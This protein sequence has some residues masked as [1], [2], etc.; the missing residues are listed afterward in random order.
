[1]PNENEIIVGAGEGADRSGS[2]ITDCPENAQAQGQLPADQDRLPGQAGQEQE[3]RHEQEDQSREELKI[4][5]EEMQK[6]MADLSTTVQQLSGREKKRTTDKDY[7]AYR[8]LPHSE[9]WDST[10][11]T[12]K[13]FIEA[14]SFNFTLE[15]CQNMT[16]AGKKNMFLMRMPAEIRP[17]IMRMYKINEMESGATIE[18]YMHN[19][20]TIFDPPLEAEESQEQYKIRRQS[21]NEVP[22]DFVN[23]RFG[24]FQRAYDPKTRN[25]RDFCIDTSRQFCSPRMVTTLGQWSLEMVKSF[26]PEEKAFRE[27]LIK[28]NQTAAS[29]RGDLSVGVGSTADAQGVGARAAECRNV[30]LRAQPVIKGHRPGT[31]DRQL[32]RIQAVSTSDEQPEDRTQALGN[33]KSKLRGPLRCYYCHQV[34]HLI[35]ECTKKGSGSLNAVLQMPEMQA[36]DPITEGAD[37]DQQVAEFVG[38]V[39]QAVDFLVSGAEDETND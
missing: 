21:P 15:E 7:I 24:L 33:K 39:G 27:F 1:M 31:D 3:E 6:R 29:I 30:L 37:W 25:I 35:K 34:G 16:L 10:K 36:V 4:A 14:F 32:A 23:D 5:L 26:S 22:Q 2:E 12:L 11:N 9:N 28:A 20:Q 38:R 13:D 19:V 17:R 8:N 18:Q